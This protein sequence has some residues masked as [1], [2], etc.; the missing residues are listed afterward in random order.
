MNAATPQPNTAILPTSQKLQLDLDHEK[1][2]ATIQSKA[3]GVEINKI[4][5][6]LMLAQCYSDSESDDDDGTDEKN[7]MPKIG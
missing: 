7:K 2:K 3:E 5:T 6:G 1:I 4:S